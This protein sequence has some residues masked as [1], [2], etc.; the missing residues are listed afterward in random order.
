MSLKKTYQPAEYEKRIYEKWEKSGVFAF[1]QSAS[2]V[3]PF[4]VAL[5]PPNANADLHLGYALD[6]QLKD[7]LG[8]WRRLNGHPVLLLPGADHAGFETWAVYEKHLNSIGKSRFDFDREELYRQ[9]YDF[10]MRN[11]ANMENQIR[12]L[13]ISCDW[14]QFTFT[15]D[16]KIVDRS[17]KT[18]EQMWR[19][20]LIYRGKRLV[21]YCVAHGTGFSDL[22]VTYEEINGQLYFIKYP[23]KDQPEA[24]L[25]IATTRPETLLGD[26]AVAVH[27]NDKRYLKFHNQTLL[28]PLTN[29]PIPVICDERVVSDFGS[30]ALKITPAHDFL[31]FEISQSFDFEPIEIID[32]KGQ[33]IAPAPAEFQGL[34][35][36]EARKLIVK[37]L[38]ESGYLIKKEDYIHQVGH[39]YKCGTVLEP[40]LA[41]QWFVKMKPLAEKA[42]EELRQ[43][44]IK[45]YPK[46]KAEELITYLGQ[47]QDWNISRQIAWGIPIPVFQNQADENDWIFDERVDQKTLT[48]NGQTYERDPDVFDTWWSSG[49]WPFATVDWSEGSHFYPQALLETGVDILRPWVSRM[50]IL[51]LFVTKKIPFKTVYLHGMVVDE[52]GVKMS[53]SKGNVV[54]PMSMIETYGTDAL[55]IS[56]CGQT[57][58]GQPQKFNQE[59]ITSGR[60]FCNKLW[61]IGRFVQTAAEKQTNEL[62]STNEISLNSPA[63]HWIW[64]K[65]REAKNEIDNNLENYQFAKAWDKI[66]DFVWNDLADWYLETCKW[67]LNSS[68]LSFLFENVLRL[69]H[70][71]APFL[72]EALYQELLSNKKQRLLIDNTWPTT[73]LESNLQIKKEEVEVFTQV[74]DLISKTRQILPLDLRRQSQLLLKNQMLIDRNLNSLCRQLTNIPEISL[75]GDN[76]PPGLLINQNTGY[77]AWIVLDNELLKKHIFKL[78]K[79]TQTKEK[80]LGDLRRRLDSE[81]YLQK[82]PAHLV[83]ETRNQLRDLNLEQKILTEEI[84]NFRQAL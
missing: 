56:L 16:K 12:Q 79:E 63:D 49:Q 54:N 14:Q 20:G 66:F 45:F 35:V 34:S 81:A 73:E 51:S 41:D 46:S 52:K 21:N 15:L 64:Q 53:K 2:N 70:P 6:S 10:V 69:L 60:N 57:S 59:K 32:K 31:D 47:L 19:E 22:E 68:F 77:E 9:V 37:R 39:C 84:E 48:L 82:A 72:T 24:S 28:L 80:L 42:I 75:T 83:E 76:K 67:Q 17:Y 18:F 5:P 55:R 1:K 29:R 8:R 11:K 40:L 50:I 58:A 7:I 26:V 71:F 33:I 44:A 23:L 3:P 38:E 78:Q 61:N 4:V 74:R 30:G 43:G 62:N 25:T 27:P 13:G 65:F 36:A